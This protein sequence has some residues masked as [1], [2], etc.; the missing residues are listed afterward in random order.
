MGREELLSYILDAFP[1][2]I[3]YVD[4]DHIIRYMNREAE[5]QYYI[6]RG[7]RDLIGKSLLDCHNE[8]SREMI[9]EAVERL[10]NHGTDEFIG[11]SKKNE[12]IYLTPV[13]DHTGEFIGY[14]ERY[15]SKE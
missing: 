6:V 10:K 9:I 8:K 4:K 1:Y 11:Y 5:Y 7:Y 15:E 14:F 13:R 12:R 3:L 2:K